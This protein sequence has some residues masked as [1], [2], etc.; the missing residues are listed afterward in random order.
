MKAERDTLTK[1]YAGGDVAQRHGRGGEKC[2]SR[3]GGL[4]SEWRRHEGNYRVS[5]S[6]FKISVRS[7]AV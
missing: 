2:F 3:H 4:T 7:L 6:A 5:H 1:K